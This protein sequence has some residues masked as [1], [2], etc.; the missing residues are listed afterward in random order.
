MIYF[1]RDSL[2]GYTKIGYAKNTALVKKRHKVMQ[3]GCPGLASLDLVIDGGMNVEHDLHALL[4]QKHYRGEWFNVSRS[5]IEAAVSH[6]GLGRL[7]VTLREAA[8]I[9]GCPH[10][11]LRGRCASGEVPGALHSV[12]EIS[13][14]RGRWYIPRDWAETE[15]ARVIPTRFRKRKLSIDDVRSIITRRRAGERAVHL[16]SEY[17]VDPATIRSVVRGET[18]A[19]LQGPEISAA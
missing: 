5:E 16:A 14:G 8:R 2:S 4:I 17:G 10:Q 1:I 12:K 18:W 13:I 19:A 6:S 9:I 3:I 15:V 7:F 11:T